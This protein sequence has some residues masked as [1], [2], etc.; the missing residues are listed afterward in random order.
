LLTDRA[1]EVFDMLA[2]EL[3]YT[4]T[5]RTNLMRKID[6]KTQADITLYTVQRSLI[7]PEQE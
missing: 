5:H 7:D 3:S 6:L 1:R 2:R 4:E